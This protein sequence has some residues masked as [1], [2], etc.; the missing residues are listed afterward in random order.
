MNSL[1]NVRLI[2][3]KLD[4]TQ[5]DLAKRFGVSQSLIA[6]LE[7]G[8]IEPSFSKGKH[9]L[10]ELERMAKHAQPC[11]SELMS[12]DVIMIDAH[13]SLGK[14]AATMHAHKISQIP[15]IEK[16]KLVGIVTEDTLL[17]SVQKKKK[18]KTVR[19]TMAACPPL[20][21]PS[22]PCQAVM[23]MLLHYPAVLV[24]EEGVLLGIITK[25]DV[26]SKLL[27]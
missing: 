27:D 20:V 21:D 5:E 14:A 17:S 15:V 16:D 18:A 26:I 11:A 6:K 25:A 10:D 2:R 4:L 3:K 24:V 12:K 1:S 8:R 23:T 7:T 13:E 9:I 19:E 22:S